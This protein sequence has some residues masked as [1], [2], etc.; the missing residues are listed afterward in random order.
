MPER[1]EAGMS[2]YGKTLKEYICFGRG[3]LCMKIRKICFQ[4]NAGRSLYQ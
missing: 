2:L 1:K 3:S 4:V